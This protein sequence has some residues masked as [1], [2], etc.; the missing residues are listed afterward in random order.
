M[1]NY[2]TLKD[3]NALT[4]DGGIIRRNKLADNTWDEIL[5]QIQ[6]GDIPSNWVGETIDVQTSYGTKTFMCVDKKYG[7]Y[8]KADGTY[9]TLT[10]M[11]AGSQSDWNGALGNSYG[12]TSAVFPNTPKSSVYKNFYE[13]YLTDTALKGVLQKVKCKCANID[14]SNN[15]DY[16]NLLDFESEF[17]LP[18]VAEIGGGSGS[19]T[20]E[21]KSY[22]NGNEL[23]RY[24]KAFDGNG[25]PF[26]TRSLANYSMNYWYGRGISGHSFTELG[27]ETKTGFCIA[28]AI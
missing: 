24:T 15:L 7:R 17:F 2:I 28:F 21:T 9:T 26:W 25:Y 18:S 10:F 23:S 14:G 19:Y 12:S 20:A 5:A 13:N 8:Q 11:W 16:V 3:G 6:A 22:V 1:P 27:T 4:K